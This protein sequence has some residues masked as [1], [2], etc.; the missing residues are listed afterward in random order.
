MN[1]YLDDALKA[2]VDLILIPQMNGC[3]TAATHLKIGAT[4][5]P[6]VKVMMYRFHRQIRA[7]LNRTF[8]RG[9]EENSLSSTLC[10]AGFPKR[11]YH[12]TANTSGM[13]SATKTPLRLSI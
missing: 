4:A 6:L 10:P 13:A 12:T 3:R 9:L 5:S 8:I 1:K 7:S 2:Y 11:R